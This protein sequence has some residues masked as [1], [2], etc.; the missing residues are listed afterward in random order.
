MTGLTLRFNAVNYGNP[1]DAPC[2]VLL[3]IFNAEGIDFKQ[4]SMLA[5]G[6]GTFLDAAIGDPNAR[7]QLRAA[8]SRVISKGDDRTRCRAFVFSAEVYDSATGITTLIMG[9]PGL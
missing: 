1:G 3:T 5:S 6:V 7:V 2:P 4:Q 8:G 9:D